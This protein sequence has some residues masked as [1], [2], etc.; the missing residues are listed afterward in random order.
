MIGGLDFDLSDGHRIGVCFPNGGQ[1][2]DPLDV[3]VADAFSVFIKI[4][5]VFDAIS[6]KG[7]SGN[8]V[9]DLLGRKIIEFFAVYDFDQSFFVKHRNVFIG[10]TFGDVVVAEV[11]VC[12]E[13]KSFAY[14]INGA[15][16]I[17]NTLQQDP[18]AR[19][20]ISA[21]QNDESVYRRIVF[22]FRSARISARGDGSQRRI[23]GF[24]TL[25][26]GNV[27]LIGI[28]RPISV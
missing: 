19:S 14:V 11:V 17:G 5:Y 10:N 26:L 6:V 23:N 27:R 18:I 1:M 2:P 15:V 3:P 16:R 8:A 12:A 22:V 24:R 7:V 4:R 25:G 13:D 20:G 21:F 28:Y 9:R